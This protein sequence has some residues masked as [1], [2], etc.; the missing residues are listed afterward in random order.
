MVQLMVSEL[1]TAGTGTHFPRAAL[2]T[3]YWWREGTNPSGIKGRQV[4]SVLDN[5]SRHLNTSKSGILGL[6][7]VPITAERVFQ[8]QSVQC[9]ALW[10]TG[11]HPSLNQKGFSSEPS[12][13]HTLTFLQSISAILHGL[14]MHGRNSP[15]KFMPQMSKNTHKTHHM[16]FNCPSPQALSKVPHKLCKSSLISFPCCRGARVMGAGSGQS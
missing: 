10:G 2:R 15:L 16:C 3:Q 6:S 14:Q 11:A 8:T 13:S 4:L 1:P 7:K 9:L 5:L 12:T